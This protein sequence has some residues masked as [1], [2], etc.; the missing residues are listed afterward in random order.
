MRLQ[1]YQI[2]ANLRNFTH[3]FMQILR[4][5]DN[6]VS[7]LLQLAYNIQIIDTCLVVLFAGFDALNLFIAQIVSLIVYVLLSSICI[8]NLSEIALVRML[9]IAEHCCIRLVYKV[10]HAVDL[11]QG[12]CI[13]GLLVDIPAGEDAADGLS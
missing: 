4:D 3:A 12:L 10:D 1:N 2:I 9:K 13:K 7:H 6:E 8:R 11:L 5:I